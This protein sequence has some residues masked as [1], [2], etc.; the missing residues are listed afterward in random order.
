MRADAI[1]NSSRLQ[2]ITRKVLAAGVLITQRLYGICRKSDFTWRYIANLRP[3]LEYQRVRKPLSAVQSRL[4]ADLKRDGIAITSVKELMGDTSL[5]EELA[6]ATWK[7]HASL[8]DEISKARGH[9]T[10]MP[11]PDHVKPYLFMLLGLQ[12]VLDPN[13]IF[14][15]FVLRP[16]VL[17]IVNS[18]FGVLAKLRQCNVW[19][20]FRAQIEPKGSQLWHRDPEDRSVLKLFVYLM[21]VDEG[22]GPLSYAPGTHPQGGI[23]I[24]PESRLGLEGQTYVHRSNDTQMSAVVPRESWITAM[25]PK[26]TVVLVD[27]RGYH[28]GGFAREHDRILYM[29]MFTSKASI[30]LKA[31]FDC[32]LPTPTYTDKAVAFAIS[33]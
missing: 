9:G 7:C 6:A 18:Y 16:E 15:R 5:F 11:S 3:W 12:P 28:K 1:A 2:F 33:S 19:Y 8:A 26:G 13:D 32:Q 17:S 20:N 21:D 30:P 14:A 4:V 10:D 29:C 25:G 23:K 22:A 24:L 31:L 27:T